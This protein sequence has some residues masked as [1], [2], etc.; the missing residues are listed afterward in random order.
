MPES[1]DAQT[2]AP[3]A[4]AAYG[5]TTLEKGWA[6]AGA[7]AGLI[8]IWMAYD[9]YRGPKQQEAASASQPGD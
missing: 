9:L 5:S 2:A 1:D 8:L 6:V 3:A 4:P 7:L